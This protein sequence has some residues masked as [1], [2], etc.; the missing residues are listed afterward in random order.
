MGRR[1]WSLVF[2]LLAAIAAT[3]AIAW[4][5]AFGS[6]WTK[7][8]TI[9]VVS[10]ADDPR[11]EAVRAAVAYWNRTFTDLGTPFR[12]GDV[13][14]VTDSVPESDIQ[15]LSRQARFYN[16]WP[17]IP[18]SIERYRGDLVIVLSN[19]KFISFT[20][21]RGNRA[22]IGIKDGTVPPLSLPNVV[23]NVIAHE[24]GHA[25][26]LDH[27]RDPQLLMCGRP[28]SCRPDAFEAASPKM[29]PLS[30]EERSQLLDLYPRNWPI[31]PHETSGS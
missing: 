1:K 11:R 22:V 9:T 23:Q 5:T 26:G 21:H 18:D 27:N 28:A 2:W 13:E 20:A 16:P 12:L 14:W 6:Q 24:I 15:S 31:R 19:A 8:P 3:G 30:E 25:L 10:G 29:F 7:N 4:S 17:A